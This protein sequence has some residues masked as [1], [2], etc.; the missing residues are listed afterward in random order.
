MCEGDVSRGC[1]VPGRCSAG[2][3]RCAGG[4]WGAC[5]IAPIAE[6]CNGED[7]DCDGRTDETTTV[8]CYADADDVSYPADAAMARDVCPVPGRGAVGSCSIGLTNRA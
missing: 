5:S 1:T 2:T 4:S 7:D 6:L 8:R 3:E